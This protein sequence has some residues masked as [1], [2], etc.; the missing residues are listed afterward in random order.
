MFRAAFRR[1]LRLFSTSP[2]PILAVILVSVVVTWHDK[3]SAES[4]G[5]SLVMVIGFSEV[6]A[7][8]IQSWTKLEFSV[9]AVTRVR[10]FVAETE[11]E[12]SAGRGH[13][14]GNWP[15]GGAVNFSNIVASYG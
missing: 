10:G 9:G 13:L 2:R 11:P 15:R 1:G 12:R 6:W 3:F 7:R 5:V 4:V 8:L 14:P